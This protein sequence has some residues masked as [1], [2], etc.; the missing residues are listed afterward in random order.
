LGSGKTYEGD[1]LHIV[2]ELSNDGQVNVKNFSMDATYYDSGGNALTITGRTYLDESPSV[3]MP[4]EKS[5]FLFILF[6]EETSQ[7][8]ASYQLSVS[9]IT[10][11][12]QPYSLNVM[13]DRSYMDKWS[14]YKVLGEVENPGESTVESV[15]ILATFYD[16]NEKVIDM[17]YTYASLNM[18]MPDQKAPFS[19]LPN[20]GADVKNNIK[21]YSL[22]VE[23]L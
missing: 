18:I 1:F 19:L 14:G 2:G 13:S 16:E 8:T 4:G 9:F 3:L 6:D 17:D 23:C 21:S 10:T 11:N 5:P 7:Q 12:D 22:R 15:K 20:R